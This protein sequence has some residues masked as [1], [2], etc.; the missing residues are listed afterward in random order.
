MVEGTILVG[1]PEGALG[2]G[3]DLSRRAVESAKQAEP[4]AHREDQGE[5]W[6]GTSL[7]ELRG[8]YGDY[9]LQKVSKVFPELSR[10]EL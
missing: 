5:R 8:T 6:D 2:Y 4:H 1:A 3:E 10:E 7:R 9:L